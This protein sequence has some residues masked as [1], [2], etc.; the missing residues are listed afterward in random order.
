MKNI[1]PPDTLPKEFSATELRFLLGVSQG[2]L[3]Q[4]E[5]EG[6][7]ERVRPGF[8]SVGSIC[9][10]ITFLRESDAHVPKELRIARRDY[11]REQT[12]L[13]RLERL[14]RERELLPAKSVRADSVEAAT[15]VRNR[16]LVVP[17]RCA[18]KLVGLKYARE[19]EMVVA[20]EIDE[21]LTELAR[22]ADLPRGVRFEPPPGR[23][24]PDA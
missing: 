7:I 8:Y 6:I 11:I 24:D 22:L 17:R 12:A 19:G 18:P 21:A 10:Y 13:K 9:G 2:R 16:L 23:G 15:N 3:S 5:G 14:E 1:D 4:L 20:A